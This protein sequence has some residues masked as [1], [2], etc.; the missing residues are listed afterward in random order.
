MQ[1]DLECWT[2]LGKAKW[3]VQNE[4]KGTSMEDVMKNYTYKAEDL[5]KKYK[6]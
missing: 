5:K 6:I 3:D 1:N 2:S 4:L